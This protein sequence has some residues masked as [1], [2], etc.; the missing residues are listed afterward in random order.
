MGSNDTMLSNKRETSCL[1]EKIL[2]PERSL[3]E[4]VGGGA[5]RTDALEYGH[6]ATLRH[7]T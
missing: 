7:L 6:T 3:F 1:E 2:L 5:L 4:R